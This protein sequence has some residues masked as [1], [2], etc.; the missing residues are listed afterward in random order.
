MG[1]LARINA[2]RKR[3]GLPV[4]DNHYQKTKRFTKQDLNDATQVVLN[5]YVG[6]ALSV[7]KRSKLATILNFVTH[8][9]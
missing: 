5:H 2:Q 1:K 4:D 8:G 7:E 3:E 6:S 9:F